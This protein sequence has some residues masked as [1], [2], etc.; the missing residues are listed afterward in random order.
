MAAG[1]LNLKVSKAD[2]ENAL[3]KVVTK[4]SN[5]DG[6]ISSYNEAKANLDQFVQEGDSSYE[7]WIARIDENIKAAGK[8]KAALMETKASLEKTVEQMTDVTSQVSQVVVSA[9][10]A[11]KSTVEAAIKVAPL[12]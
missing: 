1:S 10:E 11:A 8:A 4:I 12:L 9:T 2:F 6:V 7:A 5:L 3:E